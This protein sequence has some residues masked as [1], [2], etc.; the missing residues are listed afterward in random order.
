MSITSF[1]GR[2]ACLSNFWPI[3]VRLDGVA[4]PSVEHAYQAAKTAPAQRVG[5]RSGTPGQAKRLGRRV[6][7][8]PDW[9]TVKNTVML[10]L[11]RQKFKENDGPRAVLLATGAEE[12]IEGNTWGDTYWGVCNGIGRN[13][14]GQLLVQVR[15]ELQGALQTERFSATPRAT[16]TTIAARSIG[17]SSTPATTCRRTC[18]STSGRTPLI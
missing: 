5:F 17:C 13:V 8:R 6:P 1:K 18:C 12:L 3:E 7:L 15:R 2:W 11:L 9:E 4:Y 16:S 14:L 10:D